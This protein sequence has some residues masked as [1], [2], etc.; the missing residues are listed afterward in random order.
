MTYRPFICIVI[1]ILV[2]NS[3]VIVCAL[4]NLAY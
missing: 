2:L 3:Y 4:H 1:V